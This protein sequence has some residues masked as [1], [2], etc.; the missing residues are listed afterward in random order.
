[1]RSAARA[2]YDD[3]RREQLAYGNLDITDERLSNFQEQYPNFDPATSPTACKLAH[4]RSKS[5]SFDMV[6][7]QFLLT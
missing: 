5:S 4:S 6:V 2:K 7:Q 1:M 3:P